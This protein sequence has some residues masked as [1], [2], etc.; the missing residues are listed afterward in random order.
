MEKDVFTFGDFIK[1]P[2]NGELRASH[3]LLEEIQHELDQNE[4]ESDVYEDDEESSSMN[5]RSDEEDEE[6]EEYTDD[7]ELNSNSMF[8]N[9]PYQDDEDEEETEI[10]ESK[11]N[12]ESYYKLYTD[13]NEE[14]NCDIAIEGAN[15]N[16]T[17][18]RLVI[19]GKDWTIMFNGELKNGKCRIPIK[20]LNILPEGQVGNI[21]LEVIAEGNLFIP[22]EDKFKVKL[23]KKVTVRVN[24][25][26]GNRKTEKNGIKV[27][28]RKR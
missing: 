19:E 13:K 25:Q 10:E 26:K 4:E 27:K 16:E 28:V 23:S 22:W 3:K 11:E 24:E 5:F 1:K 7:V 12:E 8:L 18:A 20:K 6:D 14:F 17:E 9:R 15:P 21:R 2:E